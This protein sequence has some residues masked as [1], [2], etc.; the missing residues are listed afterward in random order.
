MNHGRIKSE[1]NA[2]KLKGTIYTCHYVRTPSVKELYVELVL[3]FH[4]F[5][6]STNLFF[7]MLGM[8]SRVRI[9]FILRLTYAH[10]GKG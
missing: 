7:I 1:K 6:H 4:V 2:S 9:L 8:S 10:L 5:S 3:D